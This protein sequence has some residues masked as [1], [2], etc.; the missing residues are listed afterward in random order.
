MAYT[1]SR[2]VRRFDVVDSKK[3]ANGASASGSLFSVIADGQQYLFGN[4]MPMMNCYSGA[5]APASN[6]GTAIGS[7]VNTLYTRVLMPPFTTH[8]EFWFCCAID[9]SDNDDSSIGYPYVQ[10]ASG[11]TGGET[12]ALY[13]LPITADSD[14]IGTIFDFMVSGADLAM[15]IPRWCGLFGVP[16]AD[17]ASNEVQAVKMLTAVQ[18][19]T[20]VPVTITYRASSNA[21]GLLT[22]NA[23]YYRAV[24]AL[25][26]T[27]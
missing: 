8:C 25:A 16:D 9:A 23:I 14:S 20:E 15:Y 3:V 1:S 24:P 7:T 12:R 6:S 5:A 11:G 10:V 21:N 26:Y 2:L 27:V 22:M 4:D 13:A 19:W 18:D 17:G